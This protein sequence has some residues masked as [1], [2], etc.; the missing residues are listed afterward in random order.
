MPLALPFKIN[1]HKTETT[2]NLKSASF[3]AIMLL[4]EGLTHIQSQ[5]EPW[6][7]F[8]VSF[9]LNKNKQ[10]FS[11]RRCSVLVLE[12]P[13]LLQHTR[14]KWMVVIRLQQSLMM[15][16]SSESGASEQGNIWIMQAGGLEDRDSAFVFEILLPDDQPACRP[17]WLSR[18]TASRRG[19]YLFVFFSSSSQFFFY[20]DLS[21]KM[22]QSVYD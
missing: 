7:L 14:L 18:R 22:Y 20:T 21:Y 1:V 4:H 10:T 9:A 19:H 16:H 15:T 2:V 3:V 6:L 8:G 13:C 12:A 5:I 17:R 11:S